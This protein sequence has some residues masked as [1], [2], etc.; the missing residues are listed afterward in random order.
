[1]VGGKIPIGIEITGPHSARSCTPQ[2]G[3]PAPSRAERSGVLGW[4]QVALSRRSR[5]F[6]IEKE[7][8]FNEN[9]YRTHD[10]NLEQA[11]CGTFFTYANW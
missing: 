2:R 8:F 9:E 5:L 10:T 7:L 3:Q 11:R 1:M 4:V 6:V